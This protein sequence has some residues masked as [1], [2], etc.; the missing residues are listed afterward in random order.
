MK[1]RMLFGV[2]LA[3]LLAGKTGLAQIKMPRLVADGMV[4]QRDMPLRIWGWSGPGEKITIKFDGETAS[5]EADSRGKWVIELSPKKAGGPYAMDINGI[6]HVWLRNIMVGD[7]WV[8]VGQSKMATTM[9]QVKEKYAD[10]IAR[11]ENTA[12]RQFSAPLRY[13]SSGPRD[14]VSGGKWEAAGPAT[15]LNF[16]ALAYLFAKQI[17]EGSRVPVG[18]IPVAEATEEAWLSTDGLRAF[19]DA[20]YN[21]MIAPLTDATI[22]GVLWYQGEANVSRTVEYATTF[23]ALVSNWRARWKQPALPFLL[24]QLAGNGEEQAAFQE[25]QRKIFISVPKMGLA[26]ASDPGELQEIGKRLFLA[27]EHVAYGKGNMIWT[28]PLYH[29]IKIKG[30]KIQVSFTEVERG[31]IVKGGGELKGFSI[32]GADNRYVAA[33]ATIE[34][35]NEVVV[36]SD[37]VPNPVSVRYGDNQ[38]E[39]NLYNRD[40]LFN[41]GLPAPSFTGM[42]KGR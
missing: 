19:P 13:D 22:K 27:A 5:G 20:L 15:V 39:A 8:C 40:I 26:V 34:G 38:H 14:N 37:A 18:L 6:N 17:N 36:W 24:V 4:L 2:L 25:V 3:A 10:L 16:P 9:G 29:S 30:D 33:K 35:K 28:G 23:P 32:A 12:I 7:V 42:A 21:G 1:K 41:D 11:S 31:L